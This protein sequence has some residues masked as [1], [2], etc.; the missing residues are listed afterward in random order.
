[1]SK[2]EL[3]VTGW[4]WILWKGRITLV[5]TVFVC[6]LVGLAIALLSPK[7]YASWT[8]VVPQT[9]NPSTKLGNMSSLAAMAG[10]NLNL[11][12]GE[13]LD[14]A[15]YPQIVGS[16]LFQLELMNAP[17][18]IE[19]SSKPVTLYQYYVTLLKMKGTEP[20]RN[21][22]SS[23]R[24]TKQQEKVSKLLA[25][26]LTVNVDIKNGYITISSSFPEPVLAAEVADQTR[27]LLQ[28]YITKY[29][30][31]KT[32]DQLKF[33]EESYRSKKD[34]YHKAQQDLAYFHDRNKYLA[35]A[36][37]SIEEERLKGD[38][39]IALSVYNELAKRLEEAKIQVREDTPVFSVIQPAKVPLKPS[40]P[41]KVLILT[42]WLFLGVV[43]GT[44]LVFG[45]EYLQTMRSNWRS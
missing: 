19:G 8:T 3:K 9:N 25:K 14:P 38:Y 42:V 40:K 23:L 18:D 4:I 39:T 30:I 43:L 12:T 26:Q 20:I 17:F 2:E 1:M 35:D 27:E 15:I 28:K 31:S 24:L 41:N 32:A 44:G 16:T 10:F 34:E 29:K 36:M 6:V 37:A 33:I 13:D 22:G 11:A 21:E 45:R 5:I 7:E